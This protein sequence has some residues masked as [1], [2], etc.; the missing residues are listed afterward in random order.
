MHFSEKHTYWE[1][2]LR[3]VLQTK[4]PG[5]KL[6]EDYLKIL[7]PS[8]IEIKCR[9]NVS[10]PPRFLWKG[11]KREGGGKKKNPVLSLKRMQHHAFPSD[12]NVQ[13]ITCKL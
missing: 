12:L 7:F 9:L 3:F 4:R 5:E 10:I 2:L 6:R 13:G 11:Q 1:A 8:Y